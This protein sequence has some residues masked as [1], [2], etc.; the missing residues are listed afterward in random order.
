MS[1]G[2]STETTESATRL[3]D[4]LR[5]GAVGALR[6]AENLYNLGTKGIYQGTRLADE[7]PLIR[8]SQEE[9]LAQFADGGSLGGLIDSGL[10]NFQNYLN[11]GDLANNPVFQQQME[12]ILGE[13]STQFSR[14]SV[15]ILQK[16][17]AA[18]QYGGSEGGEALGLLGGEID[19]NTQNA[20]AKYALGQQQLGLQ[21]QGMLPQVLRTGMM[22][23]DVAESIGKQRSLR[24]QA[25]LMDDIQM[26][27]ADRN[28]NL[29]NL[30]QFYE[31]LRS[32]PLVAEANQTSTVTQET[33]SDPFSALLGAA[34]SI[35]GIPT[36]ESTTLGGDWLSDLFSDDD[37]T[38][39]AVTGEG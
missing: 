39:S 9:R 16:A 26:Y 4:E 3:S 29:Q 36:G 28:A 12:N 20:L 33:E 30:S 38:T 37:T 1:K 35:M 10:S 22:G 5:G 25:E 8:Q 15:P 19:R 32:N 24:G 31:F 13:A 7:D 34:T 27:E 6:D 2:G 18:G 17:S 14:G 21:A 11:A 23:Q